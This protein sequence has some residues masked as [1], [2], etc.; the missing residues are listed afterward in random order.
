MQA[1]RPIACVQRAAVAVTAAMLLAA[2]GGTRL[3]PFTAT[4]PKALMPV[5]GRPLLDRHLDA[6]EM[7]GGD[8]AAINVSHLGD[9]IED[10]LAARRRPPRVEIVRE[11]APQ[12][13]GGGLLGARALLEG[14]RRF[15][16]INADIFHA[17]DLSEVLEAHDRAEADATLVVRRATPGEPQDALAI[18]GG[19]TVNGLGEAGGAAVGWRFTG[20]HVLTPAVF[21]HLRSPGSLATGYEG[22]LAGGAKVM[23]HDAGETTWFDI[24]TPADY[25]AAKRVAENM[26][27]ARGL[28]RE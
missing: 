27:L 18:G 21:D 26:R 19:G 25:S 15:L 3:R 12:G 2:G 10:H 9:Q 11:E 20:I 28:G 23:A 8:L 14:G 17:I 6:L 5:G 16:T 4:R 22:L 24:G 1:R 7:L 13:T